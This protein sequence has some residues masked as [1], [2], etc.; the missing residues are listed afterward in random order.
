MQTSSYRVNQQLPSCADDQKDQDRLAIAPPNRRAFLS[1]CQYPRSIAQ[2]LIS[3]LALKL[4][5]LL[6]LQ[7][8]TS[9]QAPHRIS[10]QRRN[11]GLQKGLC[12]EEEE[13]SLRDS[14]NPDNVAAPP[15]MLS[16]CWSS[17]SFPSPPPHGCYCFRPLNSSWRWGHHN[18]RTDTRAGK[19]SHCCKSAKVQWDLLCLQEV[20]LPFQTALHFKIRCCRCHT[21]SST[22]RNSH[23]FIFCKGFEEQPQA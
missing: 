22:V 8:C 23:S 7:T 1:S 9:I 5:L 12:W 6:E 17:D 11:N 20:I 10:Q 13:K 2:G 18:T 21:Q 16:S 15:P 4:T 14:Q 3:H 19:N